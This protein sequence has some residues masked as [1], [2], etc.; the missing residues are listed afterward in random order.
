MASDLKTNDQVRQGSPPVP[1]RDE[2]DSIFILVYLYMRL[3]DFKKA[4]LIL[5][6]LKQLCPDEKRTFKYLA[7]VELE[8]NNPGKTL[9]YL[10]PLLRESA[11][12][13]RDAALLLMQAKALWLEGRKA[14][15][16]EAVAEYL[17]ITGG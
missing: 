13:T 8:L 7:A 15:S 11:L 16:R 1:T 3:G 10:T 12:P 6:N 5:R 4:K 9:S 14:E 17:S 2:K